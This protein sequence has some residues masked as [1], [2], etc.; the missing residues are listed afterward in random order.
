[1][2]DARGRAKAAAIEGLTYGTSGATIGSVAGPLGAGI[3]AGVGALAGILKGAFS[4]TKKDKAN[5]LMR[6][7]DKLAKKQAIQN[8][9]VSSTPLPSQSGNPITGYNAESLQYDRNSPEQ[10]ASRNQLLPGI[11]QHL[12]NPIDFQ[13]LQNETVRN[14]DENILPGLT[15]RF[16]SDTHGKLSS[17]A[18]G[19]SRR[20]GGKSLQIQLDAQRAQHELKQRELSQ[21]LYSTLMN[22]TQENVNRP[23]TPGLLGDLGEKFI[24]NLPEIMEKGTELWNKLFPDKKVASGDHLTPDQAQ[25]LLKKLQG[26][27][28]QGIL[29]PDE[30]VLLAATKIGQPN[31]RGGP[32]YNI[33]VAGQSSSL[34][35]QEQ[36]TLTADENILAATQQARIQQTAN[37]YLKSNTPSVARTIMGNNAAAQP[38]LNS[39]LRHARGA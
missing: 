35:Q 22:P 39:Y 1:M 14:Y 33:G 37:H 32:N 34:P 15:H 6:K 19:Q 36:R 11:T 8:G 23:G 20:E 16:T 26:K 10:V 38:T 3:G 2:A 25:E 7:Q 29:T 30:K 5:D 24:E 4:K 13:A 28:A 18:Y 12:Q 17:P 31:Y 9:S 21:S 27:R